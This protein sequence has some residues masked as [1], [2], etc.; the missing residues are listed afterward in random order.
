MFSQCCDCPPKS[1]P[2]LSAV[3]TQR[4]KGV[5]GADPRVKSKLAPII[6]HHY[7]VFTRQAYVDCINSKAGLPPEL[8]IQRILPNRQPPANSYTRHLTIHIYSHTCAGSDGFQKCWM[9]FFKFY[10]KS[11]FIVSLNNVMA[12]EILICENWRI[13]AVKYWW[14]WVVVALGST[15][16]FMVQQETR[17][18]FSS[19]S[20]SSERGQRLP[21][22]NRPSVQPQ[23]W[24][25]VSLHGAHSLGSHCS[26]PNTEALLSA[27]W[28][29]FELN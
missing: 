21:K 22:I 16:Q 12:F 11:E 24:V 9:L 14:D 2:K 26:Y 19:S 25:R 27:G 3:H 5:L 1:N 23:G 20:E 7:W 28:E 29:H 10:I 18:L 4:G 8:S 17:Q 15:A 6:W 13:P